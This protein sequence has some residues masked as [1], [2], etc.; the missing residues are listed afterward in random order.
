MAQIRA[1]VLLLA[2]ALVGSPALAQQPGTY[3]SNELVDAGHRFFGTVSRD[4]ALVIEKAFSQWGQPNG[5]ILARKPRERSRWAC[6]TAKACSI[7][8]TPAT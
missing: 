1:I 2:F 3:S 8:A 5:Y 6:A 7:R 4:L